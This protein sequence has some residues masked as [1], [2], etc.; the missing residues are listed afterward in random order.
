MEAYYKHGYSWKECPYYPTYVI[1]A[2]GRIG[3]PQG[4][5]K[6]FEAAVGYKVDDW[7][8]S[9][10]LS[11]LADHAESVDLACRYIEE[12]PKDDLGVTT[13]LDILKKS[14]DEKTES[15]LI[16]VIKESDSVDNLTTA[17]DMLAGYDDKGLV[18]YILP[19]LEKYKSQPPAIDAKF[20]IARLLKDEP[21]RYR[22]I[23]LKQGLLGLERARSLRNS[24][25]SSLSDI[26]YSYQYPHQY[27]GDEAVALN[28]A[29]H[30]YRIRRCVLRILEQISELG[31]DEVVI[32]W[33]TYRHVKEEYSK[34]EELQERTINE[35]GDTLTLID[36][37]RNLWRQEVKLREVRSFRGLYP[38]PYAVEE[39][40]IGWLRSKGFKV[41]TSDNGILARLSTQKICIVRVGQTTGKRVYGDVELRLHGND[42]NDDEVKTFTDEFWPKLEKQFPENGLHRKQ[43]K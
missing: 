29:F 17:I 41:N 36:P 1:K 33:I 24:I 20:A 26:G 14:K 23:L 2:L 16:K 15:A 4:V 40:I 19:V 8:F 5:S 22:S 31:L 6:I 37:E 11:A 25:S 7:A 18:E 30:Q 43:T 35:F 38:T 27:E 21:V 34:L 13:C 42:W 9:E 28:D 3:G 12:N 39:D 32:P 10:A